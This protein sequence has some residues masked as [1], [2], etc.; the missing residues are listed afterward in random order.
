MAVPKKRTSKAKRNMRRSHDSIKAP[1]IIVEADGS[2]RR[3]HRLNLETGV[4]RGRQVIEMKLRKLN[5]FS[6][7][8]LC[9]AFFFDFL[10][11]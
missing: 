3:P 11:W 1:N 6:K 4:Y 8:D 5:S 7:Q 10:I 9:L 2:I